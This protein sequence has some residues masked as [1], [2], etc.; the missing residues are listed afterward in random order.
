[1]FHINQKRLLKEEKEKGAATLSYY[2]GFCA[3]CEYSPDREIRASCPRADFFLITAY[4]SRLVDAKAKKH[5][6]KNWALCSEIISGFK[7]NT[8]QN[9]TYNDIKS[10]KT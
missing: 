2:E 9:T 1:M 10:K 3:T 8:P 6:C 4:I 5:I 7:K